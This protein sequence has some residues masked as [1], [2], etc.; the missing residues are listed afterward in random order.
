M[1]EWGAMKTNERS[2]AYRVSA[3][4][5]A[6]D[7]IK[8]FRVE[9]ELLRLRDVVER[10]ALHKATAYRTLLSLVEGGVVV[11]VGSDRFRASVRMT[12][13]KAT[14][15]GYAS[16]TENS[17]FSRDV[18]D[19]LRRA[20]EGTGFELVECDNRYSAKVAIRNAHRLV[21]EKVAVAIEVQIH[22]EAAPIISSIF[23]EA[24]I[25]LI[26]VDIPHPGAVFFG[27]DNYLAGRI[28][29]RALGQYAKARWGGKPDAI[30][31]L[32]LSAAGPIPG[33]RMTGVVVGIREV[34]PEAE[35]TG[36]I[37]LEGKGGYVESLESVKKFLRSFKGRR[38]LLAAQNDA[39]ALGGLRALTESSR[40]LEVAAVGQ[41]AT[42]AARAELRRPGTKLIGSVAFFPEKYGE[43]LVRIAQEILQG[44]PM[45]P[46][47]FVKHA[48]IT[49]KNVD[50]YYPTDALLQVPDADALLWRFYH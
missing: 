46:A 23:A 24:G 2:G 39:S 50:E 48:L 12:S 20:V 25:P 21:R 43:Q 10:T 31:M 38:I 13:T 17:V 11:R 22:E 5:R 41:N 1:D 9:G 14:R 26:A 30:V 16:M 37:R 3:I 7:V 15:I 42:A 28:G 8:A 36:I 33:A 40:D 44:R 32:A 27:G 49:P 35:R 6:C 34:I 18:T 19:G 29:G 4:L 47:V 45:P